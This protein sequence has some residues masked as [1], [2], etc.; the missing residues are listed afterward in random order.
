[1]KKIF[2][3]Y[4]RYILDGVIP[5]KEEEIVFSILHDFTDRKGLRQ[6]WE[7]IDE[8]TQEEIIEDWIKLTKNLLK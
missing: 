8:D 7:K 2:K 5:S 4:Y 3:K 6:E 1:M